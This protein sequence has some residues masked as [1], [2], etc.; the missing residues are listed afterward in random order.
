[1]L[2]KLNYTIDPIWESFYKGNWDEAVLIGGRGFG[3]S[4]HSANFIT[5]QTLKDFNYRTLLA[6]DVSSSIDQSILETVKTRFTEVDKQTKGWVSKIFE[7][8]ATQIKR[9]L[10]ADRELVNLVTKGF[11]TS[12]I[13]QKTDLKGF[14]NMN[15][16]VLEEAQDIRDESRVNTLFDTFKTPGN[17]RIIMLNTPDLEHWVAKRYFDYEFVAEGKQKYFKLIPKKLDRVCIINGTYLDNPYLDPQKAQEYANYNDPNHYKYNI[18]HYYSD[19]LGYATEKQ[20]LSRRFDLDRVKRIVTRPPIR[21]L[22]GTKQFKEITEGKTYSMGVDCSSGGGNDWTAITVREFSQ[23][24]PVVFQM[25][26]KTNE[27]LTGLII[28]GIAKYILGMGG[29]IKIAIEI[30]GLGIA[31]QNRA[32]QLLDDKLFYRR[33]ET[34]PTQHHGIS[35]GDFGWQTNKSNRPVIISNWADLFNR[36]RIEVVNEEQ[37]Q[38]MTTLVWNEIKQRYEASEGANDDLL[39]SDFICLAN[40]D[41]IARFG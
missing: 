2:P 6:R 9:K 26:A 12:R 38:E 1:M 36:D 19:I 8:Q 11:R 20:N 35:R 31:V 28:A 41:F 34:N 33:F 7:I 23:N 3:K 27:E 13:D 24:Y 29:N 5:L 14:E 39:F 22:E 17:K 16:A 37:K 4:W 18:D 30:N 32:R 21:V 40:F 10:S 25:K 15:L